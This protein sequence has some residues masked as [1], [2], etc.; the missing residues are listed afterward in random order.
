MANCSSAQVFC[1]VEKSAQFFAQSSKN[2]SQVPREKIRVNRKNKNVLFHILK[3]LLKTLMKTFLPKLE[4]L[5]LQSM[6]SLFLWEK[7][8]RKVLRI[9]KMKNWKLSR[10]KNC[11]KPGSFALNIEKWK[12][13]FSEKNTKLFFCARI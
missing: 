10:R 13:I 11:S 2:Y 7:E 12:S 6:K 9:R 4:Y 5:R 3:A 1:C 8:N